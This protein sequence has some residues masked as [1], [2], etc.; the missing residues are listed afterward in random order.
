MEQAFFREYAELEDTH[1]WFRGRRALLGQV[2]ES[3]ARPRLRILDVGFGTG[4]MLGFLARYGKPVGMD[5]SPEA[6]AF[7]RTRSSLPMIAGDVLHV[8]LHTASVD[9]VTA[10][11][12]LEHVDDDA[13]AVAELARVCR[14]GG[15]VLVTV[16]AFDFLWGNQDVV[17]HHRRRYTRRL[18]RERV[19]RGGLRIELLTYFN[20][21]LFPLI[22]VVRMGRRLGGMADAPRSDF[23]MTPPGL[24]NDALA[25]ILGAERGILKRWSLPLGVSLLCLARRPEGPRP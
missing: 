21:L 6:I 20:A 9:L 14:P 18:L 12:V 1:W 5:R 13:A 22:A 10:F 19:A 17:S 7:A 24:V 3:L 16:P 2:L 15:H 8:P 11:D 25:A 4:A 23:A